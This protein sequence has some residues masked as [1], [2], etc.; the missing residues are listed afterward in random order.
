MT[1]ITESTKQWE[2]SLLSTIFNVV[3]ASDGDF[4]ELGR[5]AQ[6]SGDDY[7]LKGMVER[8]S[9]T[10]QGQ[11][12]FKHRI[13]L[14][15]IDLEPLGQ[16]PAN[17]LGYLYAE[18]MNKNQLKPLTAMQAE[19]DYQF[20]G[21]HITET[22]DI[23]HVVTGCGTD[24]LGEIQLEAFYVAQLEVS[25]FWL[26]LLAKNLL[27]S[28][29]YNIDCSTQYME[30]LSNGWIMGR[31]AKPLFGIDWSTL[32]KTPIEQVRASLNINI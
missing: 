4:A 9:R 6:V 19:N 14:S 22:H 20:L 23:W 24:I 18:H 27:K 21:N 7:T 10:T 15:P 5:L 31:N 28:T 8:L 26:A 12:A 1:D 30:A 25:R 3:R 32:W 2:E 17:T 13:I 16:L 29:V 11:D